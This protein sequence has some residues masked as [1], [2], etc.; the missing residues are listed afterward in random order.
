MRN[1]R[2]FLVVV[3][4][5]AGGIV[6]A[7]QADPQLVEELLAF[8][9]TQ[10]IVSAMATHCYE[11]T[12]LDSTYQKAAEDWYLRNI[13]FLDLADRVIARVG[14]ASPSQ[15]DAATIYGGEQIMSAYNQATDKDVFCRDFATQVEDGLLDIDRRLPEALAKARQISSQ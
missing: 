11:N 8:H 14:G 9:G 4:L 6:Q 5:G 13:G 1:M 15:M 3:A 7:Q 10:A 12:G 2:I